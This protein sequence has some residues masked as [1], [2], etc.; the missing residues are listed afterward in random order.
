MFC[1]L[2]GICVSWHF[3]NIDLS[4]WLQ[5]AKPTAPLSSEN[6][7]FSPVFSSPLCF[8]STALNHSWFLRLFFL[9]VVLPISEAIFHAQVKPNSPQKDNVTHPKHQ[10]CLIENGRA[11]SMAKPP[12]SQPVLP[13]GR[14]TLCH[15]TPLPWTFSRNEWQVLPCRQSKAWGGGAG[16]CTGDERNTSGM[17]KSQT[18]GMASL[19][20]A[21]KPQQQAGQMGICVAE[22]TR[23]GTKKWSPKGTS[24][25]KNNPGQETKGDSVLVKNQTL[26]VW[27]ASD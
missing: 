8:Q 23:R 17:S 20:V 25:A 5:C 6:C 4:F 24:L 15:S 27:G 26:V 13:H 12:G 14:R 11:G 19:Q 10:A 21:K 7:A 1:I 9:N 22:R 18:D 3:L 2:T 16:E